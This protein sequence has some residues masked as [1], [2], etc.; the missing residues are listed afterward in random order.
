MTEDYFSISRDA[1]VSL[2]RQQDLIGVNKADWIR[3]KRKLERCKSQT[4]WWLNIA[5]TS[6]GITGS[7]ILTFITLPLDSESTWAKPVVLCVG[8]ATAIVGLIC[9]FAHKQLGNYEM[10]KFED[11]KEIIE[12]IDN[13]FN[14]Q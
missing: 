1:S 10:A 3:L 14:K 6:F 2:A 9:V 7:S 13:S 11:V 5:F 12:E 8:I 4:K